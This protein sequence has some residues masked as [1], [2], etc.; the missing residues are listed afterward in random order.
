MKRLI[1]CLLLAVMFM[2][3]LPAMVMADMISPETY[4][5]TL[6]VGGSVTIV[7][8]VTLDKGTTPW[9]TYSFL[10][11][12]AVGPD[13]VLVSCAPSYY[14]GYWDRSVTRT[15][16]F[17]VTFEGVGPGVDT[18]MILALVDGGIVATETDTITVKQ[19][20][21]V[22]EPSTSLLLTISLAGMTGYGL[23]RRK[24]A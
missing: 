9:A 14:A 16:V 6:P 13:L 10:A 21:A 11:L 12:E 2:M 23:K 18:L 24:K 5:A 15:F 8:T 7:K 1:V 17:D 19:G 3:A 22:P 20:V 4:S